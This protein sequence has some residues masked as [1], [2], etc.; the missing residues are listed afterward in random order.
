[1]DIDAKHLTHAWLTLSLNQF[2]SFGTVDR[3]GIRIM[4]FPCF[5]DQCNEMLPCRVPWGTNVRPTPTV[6]P[7]I[8]VWRTIMASIA[9]P[10]RTYHNPATCRAILFILTTVTVLQVKQ[11]VLLFKVVFVCSKAFWIKYLSATETNIS[12]NASLGEQISLN[13]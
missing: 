8:A 5:C 10:T 3:L 12:K 7:L 2:Y 11:L 4:Y 9:P 13:R 1:M 6:P